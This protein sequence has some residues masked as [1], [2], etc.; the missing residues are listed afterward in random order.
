MPAMTEAKPELLSMADAAAMLGVSA[1]TLR[2]WADEGQIKAIKFPSGHRRFELIE[3]QRKR[4]EMG[5]S[6]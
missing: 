4:R 2:R 5:F 6:D 1:T 3:I